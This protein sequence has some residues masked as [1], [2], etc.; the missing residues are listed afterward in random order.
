MI[1]P[2][3]IRAE[4]AGK[5]A[6]INISNAEGGTN[7]SPFL[8]APFTKIVRAFGADKILQSKKE[9]KNQT[10]KIQGTRDEQRQ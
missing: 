8:I 10:Y 6:R 5:V 4:D 7:R 3:F 9:R 2:T 1:L